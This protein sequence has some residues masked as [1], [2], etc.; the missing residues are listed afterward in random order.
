[1]PYDGAPGVTYS[2]SIEALSGSLMRHNAVVIELGS[3]DSALIR[4]G[5]ESARLYFRTRAQNSGSGGVNWGKPSRGVYMYRAGRAFEDGDSSPPCMADVFRCMGKAARAALCAIARHLRLRSDVFNHLL[6]DTPLSANEPSSSVLVAAYSHAS[7]QNGKGAIGGGKPSMSSE[8][9]KGLLT[10]IASDSSGLQVCDPNSRW[11]LADGGSGAGDLLLLT[12]KALSH[13]TAGLRPAASYR[14]APDYSSSSTSSGRTSLAFR[15]MPQSNAIL[16]CSPIAAAG[17]V[18]PQSYVPISVSQF[19]DDLS[20]EE[21]VACNRSDNNYEARSSLTREPTLRS[22]L[23]DPLS[24]SFLEDAM[25]VSCGHSFGG[26]ML[27]KVLEASRCS[28][29][30][31]EIES[32]SL[33]PNHALR[34]AAAAVRHEDDRRLFHNAA[35]RKRRKEVGENVDPVKRLNRE[36]GEM[37]TESDSPMHHR[38]VQYPFNVN[39]KVVI[40]GNRRTPDK[41]VGR[42]AVITSQC[43]NGWYLLK[44]LGSGES[45]RLQYRSLQKIS[46]SQAAEERRPSQPMINEKGE[47][48]RIHLCS[49][50]II[51][52][53]DV[54]LGLNGS[55]SVLVDVILLF[56]Q[57]FHPLMVDCLGENFFAADRKAREHFIH[58]PM[59]MPG[60]EKTWWGKLGEDHALG[61]QSQGS[62]VNVNGTPNPSLPSLSVTLCHLNSLLVPMRHLTGQF[63]NIQK[64]KSWIGILLKGCATRFMLHG[65]LPSLWGGCSAKRSSWS[66][67]RTKKLLKWHRNHRKSRKRWFWSSIGITIKRC[68]AALAWF[69]LPTAEGS[70][71]TDSSHCPKVAGDA[72]E[73][74]SFQRESEQTTM[75]LS[76]TVNLIKKEEKKD[77]HGLICT[78][79]KMQ[80][81]SFKNNFL[82]EVNFIDIQ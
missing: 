14:A 12:G 48:C 19:M 71:P 43:L 70:S 36:N 56:F 55:N 44:I 1:M 68:S 49:Q 65:L 21:D 41:L 38:G 52:P 42:E 26:L 60:N 54:D 78:G 35:L 30:S 32:G 39:E 76:H 61:L 53:S 29:C 37:G 69:Y 23:S 33:I 51:P 18:I 73:A 46:S 47:I 82:W 20:A 28:L 11:Y 2:R 13:A 59:Q 40:K 66:L 22:V 15:L 24:G 75:M 50:L 9:E 72:A 8:V 81:Y 31:A 79:F 17:H 77:C 34:A 5:L 58:K 67:Q 62:T 27:R 7:L 57:N 64:M 63:H 6:D 80:Y 3:E 74:M 25:V 45:V 10:L 4:C 16:D